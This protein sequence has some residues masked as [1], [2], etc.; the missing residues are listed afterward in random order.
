[1]I[2]SPTDTALADVV[3][4]QMGTSITEGTVVSW[5]KQVGDPVVVDETLCEVSTDKVD[6]ECP[7]PVSGVLVE[8][9][10]EAEE[11]VEVGTAI[12]RIATELHSVDGGAHPGPDGCAGAA[13]E[14]PVA[15]QAAVKL[16]RGRRRLT[17][18]VARM[19]TAHGIDPRGIAGS[20]RDGRVTKRDVLAYLEGNG[21]SEAEQRPL[22]SES[23]YKAELGRSQ[24]DPDRPGTSKP[25]SRMR[26]QIADAMLASQRTTATCHTVMEC[27]M[28]DVELRRR[29]LGIT[30]LPVVSRAVIDTLRGFPQLNATLEE[31]TMALH[32]SVHLGIA[33]SLGEDGLIVP[34]IRDAQHFSTEGL[35]ARIEDLAD[36]ARTRRLSP[37]EVRGATFTITN[38]GA[39]GALAATPII[40]LP[41]VAILDLEA[42]TRRP[43]VLTDADG[44]DS[45]AIRPIANLI[46]GWDHRALDGAYAARFLAALRDRLASPT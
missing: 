34:V 36:R 10:V 23:P 6:V 14:P 18:V 43:I 19:V 26:R 37:E 45:I 33:V 2:S 32:E 11:T 24:G 5:R 30:A 21:A 42:I 27:D 17:P 16:G 31:T 46:L 44:N 20:G 15:E 22:H 29:E 9:L 3:M 12:A 8:I 38:P 39:Y 7:A 13:I 4:P 40:N 1:V 25:L 28:T 35:A 41:Q